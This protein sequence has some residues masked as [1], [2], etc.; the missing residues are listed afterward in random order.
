[1]APT[2]LLTGATGYVGGA[3]LPRL[4]SRG[5]AVRC[6]VRQPGRSELP[7]EV[8]VAGGDVLDPGSLEPALEG[9][10]T[11]FYLVHSMGRG[12][13]DGDFA[14]RDREG[15]LGFGAAARRAGVRRVVYLGG[16][17]GGSSRGSEHLRSRDEVAR[18]LA[19][20]VDDT[21]HVRA[22]MIIGARSASFLMLRHLVERLPVM[23][24]PRWID[25][26]TQP[27][28]IGDVVAAL[29]AIGRP[30]TECPPE[31]Q[32]GGADVLSYR[33]MMDRCAEVLGRRH[34]RV[35]RVPVLTPR[36]SSYWVGFVT[37]VDPGVARP[38]V[39]GLSAETIVRTPPPAGLND[40]PL[41]FADALRAALAEG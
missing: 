39:H 30:D 22:A 3:L 15:A 8:D 31:I 37:P 35:V 36:L 38:L 17:E 11:A 27:V 18:I 6:L 32:L 5:L 25:T 10:E 16:L 9:V 24:G 41:G 7:A 21:V 29:A 23:I 33:A 4:L 14:A 19:S 1:M 13:A 26:R 34:P 40:H 2:V 28:A 20:Q 12:A